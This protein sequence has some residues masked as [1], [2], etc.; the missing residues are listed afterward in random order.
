MPYLYTPQQWY[1]HSHTHHGDQSRST[2]SERAGVEHGRTIG[3]QAAILATIC[4]QDVACNGSALEMVS[5]RVAF[6]FSNA[7]EPTMR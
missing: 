7:R 4:V 1:V 2:E 6:M 5:I 3:V